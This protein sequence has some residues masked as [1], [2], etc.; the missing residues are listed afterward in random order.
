MRLFPILIL[1]ISPAFAGISFVASV[2]GYN[3]APGGTT[4]TSAALNVVLGDALIVQTISTGNNCAAAQV[5]G[6]VG[7]GVDTG[8]I[9]P[10]G[11]FT[12]GNNPLTGNNLGQ[13]ETWHYIENATASASYTVVSTLN[14]SFTFVV[15]NVFQIRGAATSGPLIDAA[16]SA[17][18][19]AGGATT[20]TCNITT[21][22]AND[23]IVGGLG[24]DAASTP[25]SADITTTAGTTGVCTGGC[26]AVKNGEW[27]TVSSTFSTSAVPVTFP[28]SNGAMWGAVA[29][30]QAPNP[31][32]GKLAGAGKIT[33][34]G[35]LR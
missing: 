19:N 32:G 24:A 8:T 31:V 6:V 12:T 2:T 28:S 10:A 9:I 11:S 33:G 14:A 35:V 23:T 13:C 22:N 5:T 17:S 29:V 27:I 16:C 26:T 1:L 30:M 15:I 7:H 18:P 4:V 21:T 3:G 34:A 20:S 25:Q